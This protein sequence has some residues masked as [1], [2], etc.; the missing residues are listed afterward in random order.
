MKFKL[1][2]NLGGRMAELGRAL[3][4]DV[5]TVTDEGLCGASDRAVLTHAIAESR[6]LCTMDMEFANP[7]LYPP[8]GTAGIV[9]LRIPHRWTSAELDAAWATFL[10]ALESLGSPESLRGRLF[11]AQPD[12]VREYRPELDR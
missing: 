6:C 3:G 9:V 2:E 11:I 4:H 8:D 1:D 10:A 7:L 5:E 12:R